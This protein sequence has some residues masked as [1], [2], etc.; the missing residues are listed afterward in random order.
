MFY[1]LTTALCLAVLFLSLVAGSLLLLPAMG[2]LKRMLRSAAPATAANAFFAVRLLPLG[3]AFLI[4]LGF[5]L[6]AFV[7]FEP[8]STKETMGLRLALLAF[9]GAFLLL[10]M[11]VRG[12]GILR[13]TRSAQQA[14]RRRSQPMSLPGV[15]VPVYRLQDG[16]SLVAVTGILRPRI[17]VSDEIVDALSAD[18]LR[19][20]LAHELA[21]ISSFDNLK[22]FLLKVTRLPKWTRFF[23]S[24]DAAWTSASEMAADEA[25]IQE[26][27]SVLELSSALIKVGRLQRSMASSDA[28]ASHLAPPSCSLSLATRVTH[29][30]ELLEHEHPHVMARRSGLATPILLAAFTYIACVHALLPAV[31]EA[32][33]FLVR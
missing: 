31:H 19:A 26:G 11:A 23:Q 17:F 22:Q 21:H 27:A 25:A 30:S 8:H 32:L 15:N 4:T 18:E 12:W 10:A 24:A 9:P 20:A 33:E 14:W 16:A 29:L 28:L 7:A 1:A 2:L 6:P 3:L 13:A 5:A